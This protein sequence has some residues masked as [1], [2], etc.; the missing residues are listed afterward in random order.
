MAMPD[1]M[2][3]LYDMAVMDGVVMT[4]G[5]LQNL[6][7]GLRFKPDDFINLQGWFIVNSFC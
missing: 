2:A 1:S 6:L 4:V 5:A 3:L 7:L